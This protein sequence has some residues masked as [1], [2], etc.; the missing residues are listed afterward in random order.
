MKYEDLKNFIDHLV[1]LRKLSEYDSDIK[2]V[3]TERGDDEE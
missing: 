2:I 1:T 3:K